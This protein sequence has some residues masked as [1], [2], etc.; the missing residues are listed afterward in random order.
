MYNS[1]LKTVLFNGNS[2]LSN[3][4]GVGAQSGSLVN[5]MGVRQEVSGRKSAV[6][7]PSMVGWLGNMVD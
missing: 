6:A 1:A 2:R 7:N 4:E 5:R 3:K